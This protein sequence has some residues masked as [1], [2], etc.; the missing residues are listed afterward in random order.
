MAD[1]RVRVVLPAFGEGYLDRGSPR[2]RFRVTHQTRD[3]Q[4]HNTE[5]DAHDAADAAWRVAQTA[6]DTFR[7]SSG[8][9]LDVVTL[10]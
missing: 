7:A 8:Q 5:V 9:L 2:H 4:V 10:R 3:G 1:E 6:F